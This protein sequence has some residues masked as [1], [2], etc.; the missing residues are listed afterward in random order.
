MLLS[1]FKPVDRAI[2][3][4]S[5]DRQQTDNRQTTDRGR[6]EGQNRLRNPYNSCMQLLVGMF[7]PGDIAEDDLFQID[8]QLLCVPQ[9]RPSFLC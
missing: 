6:V 2:S 5:L 3:I 9:Q 4:F 8:H 7:T 1:G